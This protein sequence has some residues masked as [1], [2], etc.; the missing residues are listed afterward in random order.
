M[1]DKLE[2][3]IKAHENLMVKYE[4]SYIT[5]DRSNPKSFWADVKRDYHRVV[6]LRQKFGERLLNDYEKSTIYNNCL[7]MTVKIR[8]G[9]NSSGGPTNY[10]IPKEF[11]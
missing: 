7:K 4:K 1:K 6:A 8:K 11:K 9:Y 10:Y 3:S 2:F 5:L